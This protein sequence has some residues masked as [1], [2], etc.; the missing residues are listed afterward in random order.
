MNES[1]H[2]HGH[3]HPG[4]AQLLIPELAT[5]GLF[6]NSPP[7]SPGSLPAR[8]DPEP[9]ACSLR[10]IW[11]HPGTQSAFLMRQPSGTLFGN[12]EVIEPIHLQSSTSTIPRPPAAQ[13]WGMNAGSALHFLLFENVQLKC[14]HLPTHERL[15]C[16]LIS[17]SAIA[18]SVSLFLRCQGKYRILWGVEISTSWSLSVL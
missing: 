2:L 9:D 11:T 3:I 1:I 8:C 13:Q 18:G 15:S 12:W 6:R 5:A 4:L 17:F 10:H 16:A 14:E 7:D